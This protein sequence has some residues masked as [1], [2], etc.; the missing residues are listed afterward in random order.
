MFKMCMILL[1]FDR[2][3][4]RCWWSYVRDLYF[5]YK[6]PEFQLIFTLSS[7]QVWNTVKKYGR[8]IGGMDVHPH[9]FRHSFAIYLMRSGIDIRRLQLPLGHSSL[10]TTQVYLQFKDEDLRDVYNKVEVLKYK[11]F[12][13]L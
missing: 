3:T 12:V 5:R 6:T 10:N 2:Q 4:C 11:Q 13:V 9:T 8:M 1:R 7:V